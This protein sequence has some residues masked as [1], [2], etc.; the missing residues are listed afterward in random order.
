[1]GSKGSRGY[2]PPPNVTAHTYKPKEQRK[3]GTPGEG[4]PLDPLLRLN[5]HKGGSALCGARPGAPPLDP[6]TFEKVDETF[7]RA[8]RRKKT[9]Q[10]LP[11][12]GE[13]RIVYRGR[14]AHANGGA[15]RVKKRFSLAA[16]HRFF[17]QAPKKWGRMAGQA[18]D[19]LP[20]YRRTRRSQK[21]KGEPPAR[22][23]P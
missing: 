13:E 16:R 12:S 9:H 15:T 2:N 18:I 8:S 19:H 4:S 6:A 20:T 10:P 21:K 17:G 7:I 1:M 23:P 14:S 5:K 11:K 22:V 3:G